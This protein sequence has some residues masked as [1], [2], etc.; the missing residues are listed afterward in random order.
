M[1]MVANQHALHIN[2]ISMGKMYATPRSLQWFDVTIDCWAPMEIVA[3]SLKLWFSWKLS[4]N[5]LCQH[6]RIIDIGMALRNPWTTFLHVPRN[7]P[8]YQAVLARPVL[9]LYFDRPPDRPCLDDTA[10]QFFRIRNC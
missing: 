8:R 3:V 7:I 9:A 4:L 10:C 6:K 5:V 2:F 1:D